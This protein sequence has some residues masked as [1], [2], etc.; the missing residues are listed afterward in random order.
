MP[1]FESVDFILTRAQ[2]TR[3]VQAQ[4]VAAW[5]WHEKTVA[6]WDTDIAETRAL[7][8]DE[9]AAQAAEQEIR[10]ARNEAYTQLERRTMQTMAYL[11]IA[12]R[13]DA[14]HAPLVAN[15]P[16]SKNGRPAILNRALAVAEAWRQIDA[17]LVLS[18][19]LA[20]FDAAII[21]VEQRDTATTAAKVAW[22]STAEALAEKAAALDT[23][24]KD[25]YAIATRQFA[26]STTEGALMRSRIPTQ[27]ASPKPA[28]EPKPV[29]TEPKP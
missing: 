27:S 16:E 25:W 9:I 5:T 18:Q 4:I 24:S 22:R 1:N 12:V 17:T 13:R 8:N 2:A 11:R 6:Q 29:A 15:L 19:T 23:D 28:T 14:K 10:G 26:A 3:E 7:R 21:D 20:A